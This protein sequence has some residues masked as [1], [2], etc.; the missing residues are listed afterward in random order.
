LI[1]ADATKEYSET[2]TIFGTPSSLDGYISLVADW[3]V[4]QFVSR[5]SNPD[6]GEV[7]FMLFA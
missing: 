2:N 3:L 5:R 7:S 4:L 6:T 1:R